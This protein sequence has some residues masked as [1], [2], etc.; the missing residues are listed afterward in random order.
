[1]RSV[2][3]IASFVLSSC[4]HAISVLDG[5]WHRLYSHALLS[6]Q[7]RGRLHESTV[8]LGKANVYGTGNIQFG[9]NLLLH[10]AL[11]LETHGEG[12]IEIGDNVVLSSGVHLVS[13]A[14]ITIGKGTMIGEYASI[15]DANHSRKPG[16]P[17]RD[18]GYRAKPIVLG[19]EVWI[20]RGVT[21]LPGVT[22][23]D[24]ATVGANAVVT[25]DVPAGVTVAGVPAVPIRSRSVTEL[26]APSSVCSTDSEVHSIRS[27]R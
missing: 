18:A 17:I 11:H 10:P 22:I 24:G 19:K 15:R 5:R 8:V 4:L 12:V 13:M 23:G 7:I 2:K 9:H 25:R 14:G 6:S 21:V 16:V 26:R 1:M 27:I 20:G 3:K